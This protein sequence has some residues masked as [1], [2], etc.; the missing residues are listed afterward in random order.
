[1]EHEDTARLRND[2]LHRLEAATADLP[3]EV[4]EDLLVEVRSHLDEAADRAQTE[5]DVRQALDRLGSPEAIAAEARSGSITT[6]APPIVARRTS[7][8]GFDIT[9]LLVLVL[10][11]AVL[12]VLI[13]WAGTLLGWAIGLG[14]LW[15]SRSWTT[16][17]KLLGTLVWPGG[18]A[19][20]LLLFTMSTQVCQSEVDSTGAVSEEVCTGFAMA[21]WYGI[22][23]AILLT[24]APIVV[25]GVLLGRADKRR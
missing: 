1:M 6:T 2:Y 20:P 11:A 9:A 13:G 18:L 22:P 24:V 23:V 4:R 10:G 7:R 8:R 19:T 21:P 16:G 15:A 14:M 3:L 12:T 5:A 17:E 25:A